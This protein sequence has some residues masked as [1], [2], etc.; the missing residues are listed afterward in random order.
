MITPSTEYK[1]FIEDSV[2]RRLPLFNLIGDEDYSKSIAAGSIDR[3]EENDMWPEG[4]NAIMV[5]PEGEE[6]MYTDDW[7]QIK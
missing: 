1:L 7:E 5:S 6:W 3:F 4:A 2:G